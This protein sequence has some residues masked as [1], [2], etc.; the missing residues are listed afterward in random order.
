MATS[1]KDAAALQP[2]RASDQEQQQYLAHIPE[3]RQHDAPSQ[4][5]AFPRWRQQ[6]TERSSIA[7]AC[8][9]IV[10][11][12][13]SISVTLISMLFAVHA[14]YEPV[15]HHTSKFFRI[16]Y[17][18]AARGTFALGWD[19]IFFV[20]YWIIVFTGAR[21]AVMDYFLSP[22]AAT[23]GISKQKAKV[24]FAEQAWIVL[25]SGSS[26]CV[27]LY[28][29]SH[30]DYFLN[31]RALWWNW[32]TRELDGLVKWYYLVQFAF[33]LQQ[34]VV[35]NIEERRKD[36]VQ[37]FTH[38]IITCALIFGS[39]G[40]HQTKVGNL[41]LVL[42]DFVDV[43]LSFAKL[44]KYMGFQVL[45]DVAFGAFMVGW[46]ALRHVAYM[47]ICWSVYVHIPE[48][49]TYGC[50][51]GGDGNLQGPS[52][53]PDDWEHLTLP[54]RDPEGLICWND[55]IKWSFLTMLLA[56]QVVLLIW[57]GMIIRVAYKVI[58]GI[59]ADDVR[60]DD[61]DEDTDLATDQPA[62]LHPSAA[63][64]PVQLLE[65]D[66]LSTDTHFVPPIRSK[67]TNGATAALGRRKKEKGHS[68]GVNILGGSDRK[69]LLGRIGC[70]KPTSE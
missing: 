50:Y 31:L 42:M 68:S 13:I 35:V 11:H 12:Q 37:M 67:S 24:R 19:D 4:K 17:Y 54:F 18:N 23:L 21:C 7:L 3:A 47:C 57:F 39:Y 53:T 2:R 60:S 38:H 44:L 66:V 25:Y 64:A 70:D 62:G 49:I 27:G 32:P 14:L 40:Y 15:Q 1:T 10:L 20:F 52:E 34:I 36:Y 16:S 43:Q 29:Y 56:L 46:F 63:A 65:E 58:T 9:W 48:E 55:N 6:G 22:L 8:T 33:W 51:S 69:E 28:I 59:G 45:C 41:I 5:T 26:C 30:S 61:E